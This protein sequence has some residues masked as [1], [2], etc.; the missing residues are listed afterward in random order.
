MPSL[1][2]SQSRSFALTNV[3][4]PVKSFMTGAEAPTATRPAV[5]TTNASA[6]SPARAGPMSAILEGVVR[7]WFRWLVV[8]GPSP[9]AGPLLPLE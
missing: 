4:V 5:L 8:R 6:P 2:L 1:K 3:G 7:P 9:S